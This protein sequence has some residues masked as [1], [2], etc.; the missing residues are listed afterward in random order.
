MFRTADIT[1][2]TVFLAVEIADSSL[3]Y[4]LG[5]KPKIYAHFG[6]REL[7]VIDATKLQVHVH[8]LPEDS[9]Y[10]SI[11]IHT[12]DELVIPRYA[13]ADFA[14]RLIDLNLDKM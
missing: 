10:S 5:S 2:T 4:D 14:I 13:P 12:A 9:R 7:W 3:S 6:I 8:R 1:N 11:A